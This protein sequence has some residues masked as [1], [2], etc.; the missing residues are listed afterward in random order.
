MNNIAIFASGS[1]TNAENIIR[2][3]R[4]NQKTQVKL[5]LT[6]KPDAKVI[7]RAQDLGISSVIF[8]REEFKNGEKIL[9]RLKEYEINFIV[10]AGFLWLVPGYLLQA[11]EGKIVNIHPALLPKYGGK[12]MYGDLVHQSVVANGEKE[13]G[14]SIHYVNEKYDEGNIIFQATCPIEPGDTPEIVASKV[15][16]L[17]YEHFPRVIEQIIEKGRGDQ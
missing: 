7:Q 2:F 15:H 9:T 8:D 14:I 3:F 1:G 6:N 12:G 5:I 17:E 10:L 11:F 13:S 16:Q 4:P